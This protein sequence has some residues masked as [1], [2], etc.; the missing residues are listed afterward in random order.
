MRLAAGMSIDDIPL[1][2]CRHCGKLLT[3]MHIYLDGTAEWGHPVPLLVLTP[4]QFDLLVAGGSDY[5]EALAA[6]EGSAAVACLDPV[7]GEPT[8]TMAEP[9]SG[10][11][12]FTD[13]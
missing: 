11:I 2:P 4:E 10:L 5:K 6:V 13:I 7:T 12:V 1:V 8:G 9:L 3:C